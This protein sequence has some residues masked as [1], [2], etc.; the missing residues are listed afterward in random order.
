[1]IAGDTVQTVNR[2][3]FGWIDFSLRTAKSL[4]NSTHKNRTTLVNFGVCD[5]SEL[6]RFRTTLRQVWR[7]GVRLIEFNNHMRKNYAS[8]FG[9][10]ELYS[11]KFD[12][13]ASDIEET[14][15]SN[16]KDEDSMIV[17]Y[18]A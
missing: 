4:E 7:N 8:N 14:E 10:S 6:V 17:V 12:Y 3:G 16:R 1:M 2:S 13:P 5:E 15:E 11:S 9:L 18:E